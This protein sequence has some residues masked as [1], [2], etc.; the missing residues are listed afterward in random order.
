M[1]TVDRE[2][3]QKRFTV[4]LTHRFDRD[5]F[6]YTL[7]DFSGEVQFT[8]RYETI[9]MAAPYTF[10]V[11]E[12]RLRTIAGLMVLLAG[13]AAV[14]IMLLHAEVGGPMSIGLILLLV[15]VLTAE[16]LGVFSAKC[17]M[18]KM[19]PPPPG[20]GPRAIRVIQDRHHDE[21]IGELK[22]RWIARLR[23]LHLQ[24]D[25]LNAPQAEQTKFNWLR[26]SGVISDEEHSRAVDELRSAVDA[27]PVEPRTRIT[28][29]N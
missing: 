28:A 22:A 16:Q 8:P 3:V 23:Q 4:R 10:I 6:V 15:A 9:L 18:L 12:R 19:E 11:K 24:V 21:I 13:L 7:R 1:E 14:A 20:A 27:R 26:D 2:I 5:R 17:T 29:L 25:P